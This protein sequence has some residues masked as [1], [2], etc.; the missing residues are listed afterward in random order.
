MIAQCIALGRKCAANPFALKGQH[1]IENKHIT[2]FQG[3]FFAGG[4]PLPKALP[5]GY[6][7]LGLRPMG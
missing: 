3:L 2:P 1:T 4:F 7:I 6:H 5:L